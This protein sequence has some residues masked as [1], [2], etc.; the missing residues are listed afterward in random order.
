[1]VAALRWLGWSAVGVVAIPVLVVL[2]HAAAPAI[3]FGLRRLL[4]RRGDAGR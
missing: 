2:A 4:G 3:L 1:M